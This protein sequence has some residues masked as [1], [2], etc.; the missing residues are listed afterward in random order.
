MKEPIRF[1]WGKGFSLI[2]LIMIIVIVAVVGGLTAPFILQAIDAWVF[3]TSDRDNIFNAR[4]AITRMTREIRHASSIDEAFSSSNAITFTHPVV[5]NITYM[6]SPSPSGPYYL[7]RNSDILARNVDSL[8]LE[9]FSYV[10]GNLTS[11]TPSAAK[12]V[13]ITLKITSG[14]STVSLRS[15]ARCRNI[16]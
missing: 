3:A 12:L 5:G 16:N 2:E 1:E 7:Y 4:L 9:Y 15:M 8:N 14:S 13:R 11:S 10:D 6:I